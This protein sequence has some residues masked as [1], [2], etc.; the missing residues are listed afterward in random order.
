M[1]QP[2]R[3]PTFISRRQ[4]CSY[5]MCRVS[6]L[7]E[8]ITVPLLRRHMSRRSR[9]HGLIGLSLSSTWY[10]SYTMT[11]VLPST[12]LDIPGH[13]Y[14]FHVFKLKLQCD[15]ACIRRRV[16]T[17]ELRRDRLGSSIH[18][19]S[20]QGSHTRGRCHPGKD[21]PDDDPTIASS[22]HARHRH[23]FSYPV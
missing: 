21:S 22:W 2:A 16:C 5:W 15:P 17:N 7:R 23:F 6:T 9:I 14:S 13:T 10:G 19:S 3:R 20:G 12:D 18:C 1:D 4:S 8:T 11:H